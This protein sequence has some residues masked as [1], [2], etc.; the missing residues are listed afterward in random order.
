MAFVT[1]ISARGRLKAPQPSIPITK[2]WR[3]AAAAAGLS[4]CF[5]RQTCTQAA[6]HLRRQPGRCKKNERQ[7]KDRPFVPNH[8][9]ILAHFYKKTKGPYKNTRMCIF[10]K[11]LQNFF[12][13]TLALFFFFFLS[14]FN[15]V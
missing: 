6:A 11:K 7:R 9:F 8:A 1:G 4:V 15:F 5:N 10:L 3:G 14:F 12:L 13:Y 2:T